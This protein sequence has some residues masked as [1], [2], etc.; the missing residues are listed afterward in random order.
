MLTSNGILSVMSEKLDIQHVSTTVPMG[1]DDAVGVSEAKW[2][3]AIVNNRSEKANAER[4]SKMGVESYVPTQ[5][6]HRVWKNGK[7]AK[8]NKVAIPAV[9]F[10]RCTETERKELV[11]L[12]FIFR[13]M[14]NKA[15]AANGVLAV[16]PDKEIDKLKFMLGQS[17]VPVT[18]TNHIYK[19]GDKVRVIRGSLAGLEG[20]VFETSTGRSEVIVALEFFGCASLKIDTVNLEFI[21]SK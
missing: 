9:I 10:V 7:K 16:V 19:K 8:V 5:L 6:V 11:K 20:E 12:P 13:F 4:L 14:V 15:G 1:V 17:D 18:I 21:N 2:F 3:V